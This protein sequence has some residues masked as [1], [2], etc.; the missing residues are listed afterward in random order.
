VLDKPEL[1]GTEWSKL[2]ADDVPLLQG[3]VLLFGKETDR[4]ARLVIHTVRSRADG[5]AQLAAELLG[6]ELPAPAGE[7]VV[8]HAQW[9]SVEVLQEPRIPAQAPPVERQRLQREIQKQAI[10]QRWPRTPAPMLD[11][12]TPLEVAESGKDKITLLSMLL[13]LEIVA[14]DA[15][16]DVDLNEV[17]TLLGLEPEGPLALD[18][19]N[20][21]RL[22]VHRL[23]RVDVAKLNDEQLLTIY[24]RSYA[25][26]AVS[27]LRRI[28]QEVISRPSL[29]E[30]ID[31]VEAYDILS[32]VALNTDEALMY[33]DQAR[34]LATSE[35]E[36]PA[37]WLLDEMEIR[38]L[39]GEGDKFLQLLK[40][41]QT[42]YMNEPGISNALLDLLSRYGLVTPDGRLR[43]PRPQEAAMS[44]PEPAAAS[45]GVWTPDGGSAAAQ[46]EGQ[47]ESKLWIPGMD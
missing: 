4:P 42:R 45:S 1:K 10:L 26:M 34:K 37:A 24:R 23:S 38:L 29:N 20:F 17:R 11:G 15:N 14:Q 46:G 27:S 33:L 28:A 22:P 32:D 16:W 12:K 18:N 44:E 6:S 19:V 13:N 41:I 43:I 35:G 8:N 30:R 39:R 5:I 36:S 31:K 3:A 21:E 25:V 47:S 9:L 7:N 40:E 2:T